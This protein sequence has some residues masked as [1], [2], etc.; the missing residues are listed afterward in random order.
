MEILLLLQQKAMVTKE[1]YN[2]AA[3]ISLGQCTHEKSPL[4]ASAA[5]AMLEYI[6]DNRLLYKVTEDEIFVRGALEK[7][8]NK[9]AI[10]GDIRGVGLLWAIELVK[11]RFTKEKANKEAEWIMY[12][13]L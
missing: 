4:G 6:D 3:D 2:I 5:L 9:Y 7:L 13:C 11:D 1:E 12:H 8:K 10:I